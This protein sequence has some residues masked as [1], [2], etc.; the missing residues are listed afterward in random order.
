VKERAFNIGYNF[1]NSEM[2]DMIFM[3]SAADDREKLQEFMLVDIRRKNSFI[4]NFLQDSGLKKKGQFK[5]IKPAY[6]F[7]RFSGNTILNIILFYRYFYTSY[8]AITIIPRK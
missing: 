2:C 4:F 5:P 1:T 6:L 3:R 7:I 8:W